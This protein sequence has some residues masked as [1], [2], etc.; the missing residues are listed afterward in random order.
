VLLGAASQAWG[1]SQMYM[2]EIGRANPLHPPHVLPGA[3]KNGATLEAAKTAFTAIGVRARHL[4][5][6]LNIPVMPFT[7]PM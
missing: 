3:E 5:N 2:D 1:L 4:G 7:H 6:R